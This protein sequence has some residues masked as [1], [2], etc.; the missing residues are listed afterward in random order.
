MPTA[1]LLA[2]F[3]AASLYKRLVRALSGVDIASYD[4]DVGAGLIKDFLSRE[5]ERLAAVI[6]TQPTHLVAH[7]DGRKVF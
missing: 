1:V 2:P 7:S 4:F 3:G 5:A 6:L